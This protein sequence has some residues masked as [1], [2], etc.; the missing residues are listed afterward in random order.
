[1]KIYIIIFIIIYCSV[2]VS[3]N[4]NLQPE[5]EFQTVYITNKRTYELENI[6]Q[7]HPHTQQ[8]P[9][10]ISQLPPPT[11]QPRLNAVF[12]NSEYGYFGA[13]KK[14]DKTWQIPIYSEAFYG[15]EIS[16]IKLVS[17]LDVVRAVIKSIKTTEY[18]KTLSITILGANYETNYYTL[19]I[20]NRQNKESIYTDFINKA[21][22][23]SI[24]FLYN[25]RSI[26][27]SAANRNGYFING[28]NGRLQL[29]LSRTGNSTYYYKNS[30]IYNL[31]RVIT[32]DTAIFKNIDTGSFICIKIAWNGNKRQIFCVSPRRTD[33]LIQKG[34]AAGVASLSSSIISGVVFGMNSIFTGNT[35]QTVAGLSA[36][37]LDMIMAGGWNN[38]YD[39]SIS[40]ISS[41]GYLMDSFDFDYL[42]HWGNYY[43]YY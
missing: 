15:F 8:Q 2:I 13:S 42:Y 38:N 16:H 20:L 14:N 33:F 5:L 29:Y 23:S 26:I 22:N 10:N 21:C 7:L 43:F 19:E 1:M 27:Q 28:G 6:S 9:Q 31:V 11:Q 35:I 18:Q 4:Y 40:K 32:S 37:L 24:E 3:C 39:I 25:P 12:L 34:E 30:Y 17:D 41:S 36:R